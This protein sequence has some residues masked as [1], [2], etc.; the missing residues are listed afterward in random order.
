MYNKS[1]KRRHP[2]KNLPSRLKPATSKKNIFGHSEDIPVKTFDPELLYVECARCGA[3]VIWEKGRVS[4]L[5]EKAGIDPFEL[6]A[7]CMLVTDS[8]RVCGQSDDYSIRIFR[9]TDK[10]N[11]AQIPPLGHA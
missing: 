5:L 7:A 10:A 6:D 2:T 11:A 1:D 3:P 4:E 8:C 9:L